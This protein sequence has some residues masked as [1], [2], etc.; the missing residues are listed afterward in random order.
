[1]RTLVRTRH[2]AFQLG[3]AHFW[4]QS[5][6]VAGNPIFLVMAAIGNVTLFSGAALFYLFEREVNANVDSF[7]DALWWG[8]ETITT[9][10]YGDIIPVTF[11]GRCIAV[12]LMLT[13]GVLFFSFIALL[14]SAFVEVEFLEL[15][16]EVARLKRKVERKIE[17]QHDDDGYEK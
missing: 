6:K 15:E 4:K 16:H 10:A 13:G 5:R 1:M 14:A 2:A 8:F 12:C 11:P 9:V 7:G 17:Q 3:W